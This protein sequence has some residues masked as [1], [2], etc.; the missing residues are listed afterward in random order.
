VTVY[1]IMESLHRELPLVVDTA[2]STGS[3]PASEYMTEN[4]QLLGYLGEPILRGRSRYTQSIGLAFASL[5]AALRSGALVSKKDP[6]V[7]VELTPQGNVRCSLTLN[8]RLS[9][10]TIAGLP[11]MRDFDKPL[12]S[13]PYR[14]SNDN[15]PPLKIQVVTEYALSPE[16]GRILKHRLLESRINDQLTPDNVVSRWIQR[17]GGGDVHQ[18]NDPSSW[19]RLL[20]QDAVD[21]VRRSL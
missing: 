10:P 18:E 14:A 12:L 21:W 5:K 9:P 2:T 11:G 8:L 13:S 15:L 6:K 16:T 4:V 17:L 1:R 3:V 19:T 20:L 7:T